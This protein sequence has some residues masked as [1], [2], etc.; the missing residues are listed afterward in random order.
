MANEDD[1]GDAQSRLE[2]ARF[3]E[4]VNRS[5]AAQAEYA[6]MP[7]YVPTGNFA[8]TTFDLIMAGLG[9]ALLIIIVLINWLWP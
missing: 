4:M 8:P 9:A 6:F 7:R 5:K 2:N 3:R 1:L